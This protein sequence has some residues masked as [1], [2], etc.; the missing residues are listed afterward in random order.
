L[1]KGFIISGLSAGGHIAAIIAHRA[2]DDPFFKEKKLTGSLLQIPAV[3]NPNAVPDK[4][5]FTSGPHTR[6]L[7]IS[8]IQIVPFIVRAE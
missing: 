5:A 2:R 3:L 6:G 4:Y 8:K 1:K 7:I